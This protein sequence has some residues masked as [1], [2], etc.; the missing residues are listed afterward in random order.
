VGRK[1][2]VSL[3]MAPLDPEGWSG[4]GAREGVTE[5]QRTGLLSP[6]GTVPRPRFPS[7]LTGGGRRTGNCCTSSPIAVTP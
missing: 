6:P 4:W 3:P 2:R 5:L 1:E 7:I